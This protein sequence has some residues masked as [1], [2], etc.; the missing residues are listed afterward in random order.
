VRAHEQQL[1][2]GPPA[3]VKRYSAELWLGEHSGEN[4]GQN[5][6]RIE[7]RAP[8]APRQRNLDL[9]CPLLQPLAKLRGGLQVSQNSPEI[10]EID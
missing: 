8:E 4:V 10:N 6:N 7:I 1:N 2:S 5:T 3:C 9:D